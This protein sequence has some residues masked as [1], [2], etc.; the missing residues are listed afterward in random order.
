MMSSRHHPIADTGDAYIWR[1]EK[2]E[3]NCNRVSGVFQLMNYPPKPTSRKSYFNDKA[4]LLL[5]EVLDS[6]KKQASGANSDAVKFVRG[7][8]Q[9]CRDSVGA[10]VLG[11]RNGK[12]FR[13][14]C[15]LASTIR[16]RDD[17]GVFRQWLLYGAVRSTDDVVKS[18]NDGQGISIAL[19]SLSSS[20]SSRLIP[21][22]KLVRN[23]CLP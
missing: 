23:T 7:G 11:T 16:S 17:Y 2:K 5:N 6:F 8:Y 1:L 12:I 15:R 19:G 4:L 22:C 10:N 21:P 13:H 14:E 9:R 20:L 18:R 3:D